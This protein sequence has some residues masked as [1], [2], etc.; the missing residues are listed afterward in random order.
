MELPAVDILMDWAQFECPTKTG[1]PWSRADT[2]EAIEWGPHQSALSPEAI[3]HFEKEI[4]EK[5]RTNQAR[6]IK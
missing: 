1:K 2:N 3:Q 5:T 4:K 6:V